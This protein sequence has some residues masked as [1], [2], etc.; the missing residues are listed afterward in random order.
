MDGSNSLGQL[1]S[2]SFLLQ[3]KE[4]SSNEWNTQN[5]TS[6]NFTAETRT[7]ATP[8]DTRRTISYR[9]TISGLLNG[10]EY[11]I[12]LRVGTGAWTE[13]SNIVP[14]TSTA[15]V[16]LELLPGDDSITATWDPPVNTGDGQ[17][18]ADYNLYYTSADSSES[19]T[20]ETILTSATITGLKSGTQ[21]QVMVSARKQHGEGFGDWSARVSATT[22]GLPPTPPTIP[23]PAP[24]A[25][26]KGSILRIAGGDGYLGVYYFWGIRGAVD[27]SKREIQYK[28]IRKQHLGVHL[29]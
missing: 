26:D 10:I 16:N 22:T 29:P 6:Q 18:I 27:I 28:K 7:S 21:Y 1:P 14:V 12:R 25:P 11:D 23:P 3:Y 13:L 5:L 20:L 8:G 24:N 17:F 4:S 2:S 15:P 9:A 19:G